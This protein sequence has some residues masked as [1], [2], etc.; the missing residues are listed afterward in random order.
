MK[1]SLLRQ[2][3]RRLA[4]AHGGELTPDQVVNEAADP[5]SPLHNWFEWDDSVAAAY[6][7]LWQARALLNSFEISYTRPDGSTS[8]VREFPSVQTEQGRRYRLIERV[9]GNRES[10]DSVVADFDRQLRHFAQ[11]VESHGDLRVRGR[12]QRVLDAIDD[13]LVDEE[14]A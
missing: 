8:T 6:Y 13:L 3:L 1:T 12:Y 7:R 10:I 14:V 5:A 9:A 2:E 4:E 11:R